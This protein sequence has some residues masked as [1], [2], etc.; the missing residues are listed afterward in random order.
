M[1]DKFG[2]IL[3]RPNLPRS[4]CADN[5][6]HT[7]RSLDLAGQAKMRLSFKPRFSWSGLW[8]RIP[9]SSA[10][11][12]LGFRDARD[13]TSAQL[14]QFTKDSYPR[15]HTYA[16][17][18]DRLVPSRKLAQRVARLS[19]HYLSP[20]ESF[21]DLSCSKGF[22][23]FRTA[24]E[25]SCRR[26]L[27]IDLDA[28]C[29]NVCRSL[30]QHFAKRAVVEFASLT[31]PELAERIEEFGG[32]FQTAVLVNTYQYLVLGSDVA[33][34][35]SHNHREIFRCLRRVCSGRIVFHN[36]LD[37]DD[38]QRGPQERARRIGCQY[39]ASAIRVAAEQFFSVRAMDADP[40]RPLWLLDARPA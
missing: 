39:N 6:D 26:A 13:G 27:G 34:A 7:T 18:A 38:L 12:C 1:L 22:F 15:N 32:P 4:A 14:R 5:E 17:E 21:L 33:P 2:L 24:I 19:K 30:N 23:V 31:L 40:D 11:H 3:A 10:T 36:R 9:Q 16:V 28:N 8:D 20:C 25:S 35:A 37:I 29:L